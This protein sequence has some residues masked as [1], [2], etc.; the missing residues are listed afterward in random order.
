MFLRNRLVF[1]R[2]SKFSS[3]YECSNKL[4]ILSILNNNYY[5]N[6]RKLINPLSLIKYSNYSISFI[7]NNNY[8]NNE[9]RI[10]IENIN[11]KNIDNYSGPLI[12]NNV[13]DIN[14]VKD[15]I[16]HFYKYKLLPKEYVISMLKASIKQHRLLSTLLRLNIPNNGNFNIC[17]DTHGQFRDFCEILTD[18]IGSFPSN[19]NIYLFN[20]DFVDR[21][22]QSFEIIMTLLSFKL[23]NPYC[24]YLLRGNH[25]TTSMNQHYGFEK[26]IYIIII[27]IFYFNLINNNII[28]EILKKYDREVLTLFRELFMCLP[29]AAVVENEVF[30]THGGIGIYLNLYENIYLKSLSNMYYT[31]IELGPL[32]AKMTL[33][34]I[35]DIDRMQHE[36]AS[37]DSMTALHE[38][39]WS[40]PGNHNGILSNSM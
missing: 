7:L 3:L 21:G 29:L 39:L 27:L 5:V 22:S 11:S 9:N 13:I 1:F 31:N 33:D 24:M 34:E 30:I 26:G 36:D 38:L 16:N 6:K 14:F 17:G 19:S 28:I 25:E 18:G 32:T 35:D 10:R 20:G 2:K 40:D 23:A 12:E 15:M 37:N 8:N 4:S